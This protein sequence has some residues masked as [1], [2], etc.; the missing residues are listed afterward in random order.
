MNNIEQMRMY[1]PERLPFGDDSGT[2]GLRRPYIDVG[3]FLPASEQDEIEF[4]RIS[5][6]SSTGDVISLRISKEDESF[7]VN[8]E[9]EYNTNFIDFQVSYDQIPTQGEVFDIILNMND[10]Y[11]IQPYILA[12]IEGNGYETIKEITNFIQIDS[13][14]YPNLNELFVEYLSKNGFDNEDDFDNE[15][16]ELLVE[17]IKNHKK[18][19]DWESL[20]GTICFN[21]WH[22]TNHWFLNSNDIR[23]IDISF[24]CTLNLFQ[25][26]NN[27]YLSNNFE[28]KAISKDASPF[29]VAEF[30]KLKSN[31]AKLK[32][33]ISEIKKSGFGAKETSK[34]FISL[35][36]VDLLNSSKFKDE[37]I[38]PLDYFQAGVEILCLFVIHIRELNTE[39]FQE[40]LDIGDFETI[41]DEIIQDINT[42]NATEG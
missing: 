22:K 5:L 35:F 38:N 7:V 42:L 20:I 32:D 6:A 18:K 27:V 11:N 31:T 25:K 10:N 21:V 19:S 33:L 13:N 28:L 9:D 8:I 37:S 41:V 17:L 24:I 1:R 29:V 23:F 34:H 39:F 12:I 14:I 30:D 3:E 4:A 2:D 16:Y 40:L 36:A 26:W 15:S